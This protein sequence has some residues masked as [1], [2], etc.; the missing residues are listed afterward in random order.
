MERRRAKTFLCQEEQEG[1]KTTIEATTSEVYNRRK[2]EN[3]TIQ[4]KAEGGE[5]PGKRN[6]PGKKDLHLKKKRNP[7]VTT[8]IAKKLQL[9]Q[10]STNRK[11]A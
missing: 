2:G 7:L 1:I 8:Y 11:K 6:G 10:E 3:E 9:I 5:G 4:N